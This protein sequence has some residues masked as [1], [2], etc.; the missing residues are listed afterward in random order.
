[1]G[2]CY[3]APAAAMAQERGLAWTLGHLLQPQVL[4][5]QGEL[6]VS[7]REVLFIDLG[8]CLFLSLGLILPVPKSELSEPLAGRHWQHWTLGRAA[9]G[10]VAACDPLLV[11]FFGPACK[12]S[13]PVG[14]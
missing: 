4:V 5:L 7:K 8:G 9:L 11:V 1:M 3:P 12:A 13:L 14:G 10:H 6:S 2:S